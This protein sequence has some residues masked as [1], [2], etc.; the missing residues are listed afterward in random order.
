MSS[1]YYKKNN[2]YIYYNFCLKPRL[3]HKTCHINLHNECVFKDRHKNNYAFMPFANSK[4]R[5]ILPLF[6]SYGFKISKSDIKF[7]KIS[8]STQNT[9]QNPNIGDLGCPPPLKK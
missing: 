3:H 2:D 9:G 4:N 6:F 5:L 7:L 8:N 1:S